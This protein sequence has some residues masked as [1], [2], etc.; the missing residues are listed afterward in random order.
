MKPDKPAEKPA[1]RAE[2][3]ASAEVAEQPSRT[4]RTS[5]PT[6]QPRRPHAARSTPPTGHVGRPRQPHPTQTEGRDPPLRAR[7]RATQPAAPPDR[8]ARRE[9]A[10]RRLGTRQPK[11]QYC[12]E[13]DPLALQGVAPDLLCAE[14]AARQAGCSPAEKHHLAWQHNDPTKTPI[15]GND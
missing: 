9:A 11:C 7:R 15:P 8:A 2:P 12:S 4:S 14:C 3:D 5:Q 13:T 10:Y 1:E 6:R